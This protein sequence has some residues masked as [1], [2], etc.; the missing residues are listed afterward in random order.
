MVLYQ[1]LE[2]YQS[3]IKNLSNSTSFLED[4]PKKELILVVDDTSTN[5]KLVSDFLKDAGFEVWVAKNGAQAL[6][7]VK[8]ALP[9]L[10]LLDVVMPVLNGFETCRRLKADEKTQE[11]PVIFM[12]AV[13]DFANPENKIKGLKLGAVD[14]ISKPIQLE[15]VLARVKTHLYLRSLTNQ[16]QAQ[17]LL[18]AQEI[19]E[20]KQAQEELAQ[21]AKRSALRADIGFA[22]CQEGKLSTL[23]SRCTE[24]F[25][26]HLN[27]SFAGIWTLN[28][29]RTILELQV[30]AGMSTH[31]KD[32]QVRFPVDS[33]PI[34][35]IAFERQLHLSHQ[36]E[37]RRRG[38]GETKRFSPFVVNV[39]SWA[40]HPVRN[41]SSLSNL[42]WQEEELIALAGYPLIVEEQLVGAIA[43][44]A[45]H[46]LSENTLDTIA[47]VANEIGVGIERK[48]AEEKLRTSE[49]RLA[50]AQRVAHVGCWEFDVRLQ[51]IIW[52]EELFHIFG[53][54]PTQPEPPLVEH[55]KQIHP[56][57]QPLWRKTVANALTSATSYHFEF[58]AI[59]PDGSIRYIEAR[60]EAVVN[61]QGQVIKLFGTAL[62]ITERKLKEAALHQ[63]QQEFIA[64]VENS[65]DIVA[66]LDHNL[67]HLYINPV[68]QKELGIPCEAF[69][70]K[71]YRELGFPEE[72]LSILEQ[73][74]K[75]V[76]ETGQEHTIELSI[77]SPEGNRFYQSRLVPEKAPD[78]SIKSLLTIARDITQLKNSEVRER[79]KAQELEQA[80]AQ[81]KQTQSQLIQ[82]EKMSALG[83]MVAG[84][85]HEIN[86]PISFIYGNLTYV[87]EY[88][89][90]LN[91]LVE[92]YQHTYPNS[93][94]EIQELIV[95]IDLDFLVGDWQKI[96]NS[97]QSGAERIEQIIHSLKLFARLN[98][99]EL[100][101]VN[102]HES[103]EQSLLIV[104]HRLESP[105]K[106]SG[107]QVIKNYGQLPLINCYVSQLNQVFMNLLNNAIDVLE[108]SDGIPT[109]TISTEVRNNRGD[110]EPSSLHSLTLV[111]R[112]ADNG[113]GMS[114]EVQQ[115]IFDPFFTTKPVGQGTGLALAISH[116][117]VVE[118]HKGT[119]RC[120]SAIGQGTEFIVEI[121][122]IQKN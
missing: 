7:I 55:I 121:P 80:L 67:R 41:D 43:L 95:E 113:K 58:R 94:A 90:D 57:D 13:A 26:Q 107:I 101:S 12:T 28:P 117:I 29:D 88:F 73:G 27:I 50:E 70:G 69:I 54:D 60:G 1:N 75:F 86:N 118:K 100:K 115:Q 76:F 4:T 46:P 49:A 99:A 25:V 122:V 112:I 66:R 52:S 71:T 109:I 81:L 110:C 92:L 79:T 93:T 85:A 30:W 17:N 104:Q 61:P 42:E 5:L 116:Q 21:S 56:E 8:K 108:E 98:E 83:R 87:K 45:V 11:I 120:V 37:T 18:L 33:Y 97:M 62:D 15:E 24:A 14:Y 111:I 16:L 47:T 74:A 48:R 3:V 77:L 2:S 82:A 44:F 68:A 84:V 19:Q 105:G 22:L 72:P 23:L 65:P 102:I 89:Q 106:Q 78:G 10:I 53:L 9:D 40:S 114:E 51:K 63:R 34:G 20:R 96:I 39:N 38:D 64:L 103:L 31:I 91:R 119:I 32:V 59:R 6:N 36:L 35:F